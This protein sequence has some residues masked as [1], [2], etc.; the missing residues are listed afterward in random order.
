[1]NTAKSFWAGWGALCA[2]GGTAYY[3]AKQS[4]NADRALKMEE[5]RKKK[6]Q[7]EQLRM[8]EDIK[9]VKPDKGLYETPKPFKSPKGDRFS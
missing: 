7:I 8:D 4:I 5:L 9:G 1:M 3:F 2:A 6:Q